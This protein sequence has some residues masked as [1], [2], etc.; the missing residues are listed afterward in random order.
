MDINLLKSVL[1]YGLLLFTVGKYSR[2]DKR[3]ETQETKK[4]IRCLRRVKIFYYR[5][6]YCG[7]TEFNFDTD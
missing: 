2:I 6:P 7:S 1:L 4:C 3:G 5:C